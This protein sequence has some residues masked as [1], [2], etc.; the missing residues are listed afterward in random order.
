MAFCFHA[1]AA[2]GERTF[3]VEWGSKILWV[4]D[5]FF[6]RKLQL[7][8]KKRSDLVLFYASC[9]ASCALFSWPRRLVKAGFNMVLPFH[10]SYM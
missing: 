9:Q 4:I 7:G 2:I 5:Y 10:I 8:T 6:K 3:L 1:Y